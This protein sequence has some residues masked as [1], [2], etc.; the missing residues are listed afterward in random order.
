MDKD[1]R[2]T[3]FMKYNFPPK[4]VNESRIQQEISSSIDTHRI[5]FLPTQDSFR[6]DTRTIDLTL[7]IF[8]TSQIRSALKYCHLSKIMESCLKED[9]IKLTGRQYAYLS[10]YEVSFL[11]ISYLN[12]FY[13]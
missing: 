8:H 12:K 6:N 7:V 9:F 11:F 3:T 4:L 13:N 10:K 2:N 5:L 1:S